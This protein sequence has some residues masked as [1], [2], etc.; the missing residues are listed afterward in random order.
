MKKVKRYKEGGET[1]SVYERAKRFLQAQGVTDATPALD[2]KIK[3]A[4]KG[5]PARPAAPKPTV[6]TSPPAPSR[7]APLEATRRVIEEGR[8]LDK[9]RAES[10][11]FQND[12]GIDFPAGLETQYMGTPDRPLR[13][14]KGGKVGSASRRADG[15][16]QRGKTRGKV[17]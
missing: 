15:I 16:A 11:R 4:R 9:E 1:E 14:A 8:R 2:E 6:R 12:F 5:M 17:L 3:E 10:L 13:Y 7:L